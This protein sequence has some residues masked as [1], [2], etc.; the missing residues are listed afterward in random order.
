MPAGLETWVSLYLAI[1]KN[2]ERG[3][4][5]YDA[6][7]DRANLNW[8]ATRTRPRSNATKS[9]FDRINKAN[10]TIYRYDLFGTRTKAFA[11]DFSYHP[12]GGCV[13]GKATDNY[14]RVPDTRTS[15]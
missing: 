12:L 4:F 11:D 13:L 5:V 9:L 1:T 8:T 7:A 15:T 6:A 10:A 14:G 3:S 2:P